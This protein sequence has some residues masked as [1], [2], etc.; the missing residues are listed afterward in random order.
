MKSC[1]CNNRTTISRLMIFDCV[2]VTIYRLQAPLSGQQFQ[3]AGNQM[4]LFNQAN[5]IS[6]ISQVL[7]KI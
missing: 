7:L 6:L 5:F 3:N 4:Q 1:P 2:S